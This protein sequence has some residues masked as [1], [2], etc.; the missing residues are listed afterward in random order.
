LV[1]GVGRASGKPILCVG[2]QGAWEAGRGLA[3]LM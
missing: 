3:A 1:G 2:G